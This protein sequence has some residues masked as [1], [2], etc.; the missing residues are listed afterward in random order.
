MSL[1]EVVNESYR[2]SPKDT[3]RRGR[4]VHYGPY[5][6]PSG[7]STRLSNGSSG[8]KWS[9]STRY[10]PQLGHLIWSS[11]GSA[12]LILARCSENTLRH[13]EHTNF[14][15]VMSSHP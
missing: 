9:V 4:N 12:G 2:C 6:S 14:V 15:S 8:S 5:T 7:S 13:T 3:F 10:E 1:A 11:S